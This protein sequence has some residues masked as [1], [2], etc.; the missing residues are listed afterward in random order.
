MYAIR[1][2]YGCAVVIPEGQIA[3]GKLAQAMV[4]GARVVAVRGNFDR[5]LELVRTLAEDRI[6]SYNVC[7]TKLLRVRIDEG[8]GAG[9][10]ARRDPPRGV[11]QDQRFHVQRR[12]EAHHARDRLRIVTT[13]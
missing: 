7:Y 4:H 11:R 6:T 1:S 13:T 9:R 10:H 2:Y 3:L 12:E 5:A 8:Q